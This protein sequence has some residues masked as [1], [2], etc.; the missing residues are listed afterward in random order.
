M[1]QRRPFPPIKLLAAAL[2]ALAGAGA[3]AQ[4][5][6]H[7]GYDAA[8]DTLVVDVAYRGSDEHHRF[9]LE[10][11]SCFA[12]ADGTYGVEA[13]V[14][15]AQGGDPALQDLRA[16]ERFSLDRIPCRPADVT[17]RI[18]RVAHQTVHVPSAP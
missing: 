17:L 7:A 2:L 18:G 5:I 3:A 11:G 16:R 6:L 4:G 9:A 15:D 1:T 12:E 8:H 14:I 13:R 10:W